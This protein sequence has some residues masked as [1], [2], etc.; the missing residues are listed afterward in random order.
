MAERISSVDFDNKVIK[1]DKPVIVEFYSDSCVACKKLS[2]VLAD[3]EDE[4]AGRVIIY[5][6]NTGYDSQL[7]ESQGVRANPT[8]ISY[9]DGKVADRRVGALKKEELFEFIEALI[10]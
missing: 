9:T 4:Y 3:A 5:K 1:A 10:K 2:P 6:V 8:L 7:A